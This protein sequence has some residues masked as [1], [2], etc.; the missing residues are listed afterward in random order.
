MLH[1]LES[2]LLPCMYKQH[3]GIECP[4]CGM[5]RSLIALLRGDF[6][7]SF[8]L[9][10]ALLPMLFLFGFLA[11]HLWRRFQNGGTWLKYLFI[12][13]AGLVVGHYIAK[14]AGVW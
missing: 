13:V 11:L 12:A 7:E 3:L 10:P 14:L 9:Y 2:H 6:A 4:G 8:H 1:W 5:Q